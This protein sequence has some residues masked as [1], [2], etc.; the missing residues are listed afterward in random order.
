MG[1]NIKAEESMMG[2]DSSFVC[3]VHWDWQSFDKIGNHM[4][5][6]AYTLSIFLQW[7]HHF[8]YSI[9]SKHDIHLKVKTE[10]AIDRDPLT[11][12]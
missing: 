7:P 8:F 5:L 6:P 4:F 12:P 9:F 3:F 1:P 11:N 2:I 10:V